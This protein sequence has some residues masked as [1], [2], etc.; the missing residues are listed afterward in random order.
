MRAAQC[1]SENALKHILVQYRVF[2]KNDL[3]CACGFVVAEAVLPSAHS[4]L[5]LQHGRSRCPLRMAAS[6]WP[7]AQPGA[8]LPRGAA[9]V[10]FSLCADRESCWKHEM[11]AF[12]S[13]FCTHL[14][15]RWQSSALLMCFPLQRNIYI[16]IKRCF[17]KILGLISIR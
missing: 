12:R 17:P 15:R 7:A 2:L 14:R 11:K 10:P 8:M 5:C 4:S 16:Y 9:C 6:C 1:L 3:L 13:F